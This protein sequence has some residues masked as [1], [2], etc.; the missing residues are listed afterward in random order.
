MANIIQCAPG[1]AL[2]D[3]ITLPVAYDRLIYDIRKRHFSLS[4]LYGIMLTMLGYCSQASIP[5]VSHCCNLT[6]I[7]INIIDIIRERHY[8]LSQILLTSIID[9]MSNHTHTF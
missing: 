5:I 8:S 9:I 6:A 4:D 1:Y 7:I 2:P 3:Y